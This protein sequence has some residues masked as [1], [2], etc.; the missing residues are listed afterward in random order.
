VTRSRLVLASACI[1]ASLLQTAASSA[2]L[3]VQVESLT[4]EY[5]KPAEFQLS[6][7]F[8]NDGEAPVIVLPQSLRRI[9][10]S[11]DDG[12]ARYSPYPGPPI[13]PWRDAFLLQ[14]GQS[15]AIAVRAMRDRDGVWN[16][17]PGRYELSVRLTVTP[18]A[19]EAS[20]PHLGHLQAAIWQGD[21]RSSRI[22]VTYSPAPAA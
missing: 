15:R 9:Y 16:L 13:K 12:V 22:R 3:T 8:R 7:V 2:T 20:R 18:A 5:G 4:R 6:V 11:L 1:A 19:V 14:P 10:V 21:V 17:E